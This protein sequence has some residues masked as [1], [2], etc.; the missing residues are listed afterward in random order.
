[1]IRW[2]RRSLVAVETSKSANN[3]A[4]CYSRVVIAPNLRLDSNCGNA[5]LG[6]LD[7]VALRSPQK[8]SN[9][10]APAVLG[11]DAANGPYPGRGSKV[12]SDAFAV[13]RYLLFVMQGRQRTCFLSSDTPGPGLPVSRRHGAGSASCRAKYLFRTVGLGP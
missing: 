11:Y 10:R 7:G 5:L 12:V 8:A 2:G 6:S 1:M 4:Q 3:A 13:F 9:N